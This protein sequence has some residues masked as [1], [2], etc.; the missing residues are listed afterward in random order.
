MKRGEPAIVFGLIVGLALL[1]YFFF[2][3]SPGWRDSVDWTRVFFEGL[4][5][6]FVF[7]WNIAILPRW[8]SAKTLCFGAVLFLIGSFADLYD[9]FFIQPRWQDWAIEDLSL[10]FGAGLM[11]LGI[12]FWV[13]EKE[14]MLAQIARE[15]DFEASLI[16]KLSH[17]LRVPLGNVIGMSSMAAE[18]PH[19]FDDP[20]QRQK[21]HDVVM[22]G[23]TEMNLLIEN[24]LETHRMKSGTLTLNPQSLTVAPLLDTS[25]R[26]FQYQAKRKE[27]NL[28]K[29]CSRPDLALVAD[30]PKVVRIVQNLLA[31]AVKFSPKG[32]MITVKANGDDDKVTVRVVDQGPGMTAALSA[33]L[34]DEQSPAASTESSG[35]AD[36]FGLGLKVVRE[37]VRLHGGRLWIEPN[38]PH[39]T[40]VCFSL[41]QARPRSP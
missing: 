4:L 34:M 12:F 18:D 7:L 1:G 19:F 27:L 14:R 20:A 30:G 28:V 41:P 8:E 16:P 38:S 17:D 5:F 21:Y 22:R 15:R 32:G 13:R 33:A 40:Q 26:D 37:F 6:F 23:A 24:I 11:T 10:A 39:G 35:A 2:W 36:S 25:L 9:N 29:D 3:T 31:N